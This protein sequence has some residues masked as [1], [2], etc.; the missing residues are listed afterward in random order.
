MNAE[1]ILIIE[2]NEQNLDMAKDLLQRAGFKTIEAEDADS[3]I[4]IAK[5]Q[6]PALIL[7]DMHLPVMNGYEASQILKNDPMTR[8][9]PIVGFTALAMEED[10]KRAIEHGCIGVIAKP[11]DVDRFAELVASYLPFAGRVITM[12]SPQPEIITEKTNIECIQK[13]FVTKCYTVLAVDDNPQNLNL[14]GDILS[15]MHQPYIFATNGREA[16]YLAKE[17]KPDLILLD[18]MMPDITG[19]DVLKELKAD[20]QTAS[21]PVIFVSAL[22]KSE[23][24]VKGLTLGGHDYITKPFLVE[25]VQARVEG[26]LRVKQYQDALLYQIDEAQKAKK[27]LEEFLFV[28]SHDLQSPLRKIQQFQDFLAKAQSSSTIDD[29]RDMIEGI[30]RSTEQMDTLLREL[31]TLSRINRNGDPFSP[32]SLTDVMANALASRQGRIREVGATVEVGDM[33]TVEA[34]FK[35]ME[36]LFEALIDN[37]LKFKRGEPPFIRI[38]AS[39][40]TET[41]E[42]TVE[43]N[44]IGFDEAHLERIFRPFQRLHGTS[45]YPGSGMGLAIAQKIAVRHHGSIT[46]KSQIGVG[47]IFIVTLPLS[48]Y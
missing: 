40:L 33:P 27:D 44:G 48:R 3:G 15:L 38:Q 18:I 7:M 39:K 32:I 43:D 2:D 31:L 6:K 34:D 22:N 46:A 23:D 30:G 41:C 45:K 36:V 28:A 12:P 24:V 20:P 42:I 16:L 4:K 11:I 47:S 37:A 14:L 19:Y 25:E 1:T 5:E 8:D 21:I 35:Q 26:V 29:N 9:I 13:P 17:E 10:Q